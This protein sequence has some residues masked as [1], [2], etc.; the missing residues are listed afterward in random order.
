MDAP[1]ADEQLSARKRRQEREHA[2]RGRRCCCGEVSSCDDSRAPPR[3]DEAT[4]PERGNREVDGDAEI[5]RR[6]AVI[7]N[8]DG[9]QEG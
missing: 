6:H 4:E 8:L 3:V 5:D 1:R 7:D 9:R 2:N